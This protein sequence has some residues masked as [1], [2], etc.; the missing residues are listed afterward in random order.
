[1]IEGDSAEYEFLTEGVQLSKDVQG[2]CCEVGLRLGKGTQTIIDACVIHRPF[3]TV[4]SIDPFG[5]ILYTG[6]EHVGPIRLDYTNDMGK[7]CNAALSEYV[8]NKPVWWIPF[9]MTDEFF[10]NSFS[11]GIELY[12]L[13]TTI[14]NKYAF[15]HLDG[16]HHYEAV[17]TEIKWFNERMDRG[18]TIVID[19]I[20]IDFID[21]EPIHQLLDSLGW[22]II[23][24]GAKKGLYQKM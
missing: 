3:S 6:R 23:K 12:E 18:S 2:I 16:P 7:I 22:K 13:E 17:S 21:I 19:D 1:M 4:I 11:K 8:I 20:T 9:K 15:V 5:S 10:F 24:L 14:C